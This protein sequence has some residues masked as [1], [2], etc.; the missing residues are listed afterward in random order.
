MSLKIPQAGHVTDYEPYED[1]CRFVGIPGSCSGGFKP[2]GRP[3]LSNV[4]CGFPQSLRVNDG[5]YS[6]PSSKRSPLVFL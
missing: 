4:P 2:R 5:T 6:E 3:T 1:R